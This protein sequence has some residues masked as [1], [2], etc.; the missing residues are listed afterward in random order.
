MAKGARKEGK[1]DGLWK[2]ECEVGGVRRGAL[3]LLS[4]V[5]EF[6]AQWS[7][8]VVALQFVLDWL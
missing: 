8:D 3:G 1:T 4:P 7:V 6:Q 5:N 2:G